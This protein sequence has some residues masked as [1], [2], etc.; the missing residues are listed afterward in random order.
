[1]LARLGGDEF[2]LLLPQADAE[3]AAV[4]AEALVKAVRQHVAALGE[5]TIRMTASVG[6]ALFG[7]LSYAE[8]LAYADQAMYEAKESGRDRMSSTARRGPPPSHRPARRGRAICAERSPMT[9]SCS[10]PSRS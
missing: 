8:L 1:M 4:V 7:D 10:T 9:A 5:K 2:A 6:V 3:E